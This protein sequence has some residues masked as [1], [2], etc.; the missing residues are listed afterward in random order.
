MP[1]EAWDSLCLVPR[2]PIASVTRIALIMAGGVLA[3]AGLAR[4]RLAVRRAPLMPGGDELALLTS[5]KG[6][7]DGGCSSP[8][9]H[10]D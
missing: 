6:D 4:G 2:R 8:V 1:K 9:R 3:A 7:V 10:A 5:T